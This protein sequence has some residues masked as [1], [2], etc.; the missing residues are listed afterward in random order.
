MAGISSSSSSPLTL[1]ISLY[2]TSSIWNWNNKKVKLLDETWK[3]HS[4][5]IQ[6]DKR[7]NYVAALMVDDEACAVRQD[8][9][10]TTYPTCNS[11][12]ETDNTAHLSDS[13][14]QNQRCLLGSRFYRDVWLLERNTDSN[15]MPVVESTVLKTIRMEHDMDGMT[16]IGIGV[17]HWCPNASRV[18]LAF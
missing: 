9:Q 6:V 3:D 7:A 15:N 8:W 10:T 1:S 13:N 4:R 11:L 2:V 17:M 14:R 16:L 5:T 18:V 12:H